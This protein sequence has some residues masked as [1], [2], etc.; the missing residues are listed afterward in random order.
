MNKNI[1]DDGIRKLVIREGLELKAYQDS[2]GVWTIGVGHTGLV[3]GEPI[4]RGMVITQETAVRLLKS[5][6]KKHVRAVNRYVTRNV[7]QW[8]F[9]ALVSF[10]FNVGNTAFRNS[11]LLKELNAGRIQNVPHELMRWNKVTRNG[12]KV[13]SN[14]LVYRRVTECAQWFGDRIRKEY[15]T[16]GNGTLDIIV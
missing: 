16:A 8:R 3:D 14:G 5:D 1:S 11:T 12:K 10:A 9:D 6:L 7:N 15:A 4:K 13:R 2:A